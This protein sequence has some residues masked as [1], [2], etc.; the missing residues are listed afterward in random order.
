MKKR[1]AILGATGSI[2]RQTID[3]IRKFPE[4]FEVVALTTHS[5]VELLWKYACEFNPRYLGVS[6]RAYSTARDFLCSSE[7]ALLS[8]K[9]YLS[10]IATL[11]EVDLVVVAV[12]G[13]AGLEPT[14]KALQAGK[15]VA[16]AT[17]EALVVAGPIITSIAQKGQLIPVDSE[18]SAAM[19]C[20]VGERH[21]DI[22]LLYLPASGGP[23]RGYTFQQLK[24]VSV[25]QALKHPKWNMG[26]KITIDSATL[27][28]KGLELIEAVHLFNLTPEQIKVVIHPQALVHAM[29]L[30][31]DG[32][33]KAQISKPD[34]RIPIA[35]A[36]AYPQRLPL[37]I[38]EPSL[39][40]LSSISFEEPDE[41]TFRALKLARQAA[42]EGGDRPCVLNAANEVA[43]ES[44]L[45]KK[46]PFTGISQV[47]EE[48]LN[49]LPPTSNPDLE[50]LYKI[51]LEARQLAL[52]IITKISER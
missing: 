8:G 39:E 51:D 31:H 30:F 38:P 25:E 2:G 37:N 42:K 48:T 45:Q 18:H 35:L 29:V 10:D 52:K 23:F 13:F 22:S 40:D 5:N 11:P 9:N 21:Q 15:T 33:I 4:F 49:K 3:V 1:I 27:M 6:E 41:E 12:V 16:L 50:T 43:V 26:P 14:I 20:L 36:L 46:I 44:F 7:S 34:M 24:D 47:V 17:K 19:Q 28:N 32:S